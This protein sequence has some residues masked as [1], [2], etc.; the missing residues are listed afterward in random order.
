M[1]G[2]GVEG[3]FPA[4]GAGADVAAAFGVDVAEGEVEQFDRGVVVGEVAAVLGDLAQL[5]VDRLD[6]RWWCR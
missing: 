4:V 3:L 1:D 5:V 6:L 2:E